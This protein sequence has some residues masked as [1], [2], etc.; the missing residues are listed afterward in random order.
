MLDRG[1]SQLTVEKRQLAT[2]IEQLEKEMEEEK[3]RQE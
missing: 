2:K 1:C 3:G